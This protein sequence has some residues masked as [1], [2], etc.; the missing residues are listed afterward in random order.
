MHCAT[1]HLDRGAYLPGPAYPRA[2]PGVGRL[3]FAVGHIRPVLNCCTIEALAAALVDTTVSLL[4]HYTSGPNRARPNY[5]S[6]D[7]IHAGPFR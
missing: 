3:Q 2:D 4:T 6:F 1:V 7:L 5:C